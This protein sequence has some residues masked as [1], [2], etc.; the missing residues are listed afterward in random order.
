MA[1]KSTGEKSKKG[2][3]RGRSTAF[4]VTVG[5]HVAV[6]LA[7]GVYT[8]MT[9][10]PRE[11]PKFES[12]PVVRPKMPPKKLQV[13]VKVKKIRQP[14][15]RK[16]T[17]TPPKNKKMDVKMPAMTGVRG[18]M[19]GLSG[20]GLGSLGF[21]LRMDAL[22][23]NFFGAKGG[24]KHIVFIVDYSNSMS[25]E[26]EIVMRRE[27]VRVLKELPRETNVGL[28]FFAGPAWPAKRGRLSGDMSNW[29]RR[30][31][32]GDAQTHRPK[33][34]EDLP[35]VEYDRATKGR[36][37]D[38]VDLVETTS[39][40]GGTVYD[41][42]IYM[43]L[44][45]DPIPDTIFFMTD[46]ACNKERSVDSLQKMLTQLKAGGKKIPVLHTVGLGIGSNNMLIQM[47]DMMGGKSNFLTAEE[48]VQKYG[49]AD[50]ASILSRVE[51]KTRYEGEKNVPDEKYPVHFD[52]TR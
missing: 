42:P 26:K 36:I 33:N 10:L 18:A 44:R 47:A 49:P 35:E 32:K 16:T 31:G 3:V 9:V 38:L 19:D 50:K 51:N 23:I 43:A 25:G 5:V 13:P 17:I 24:G 7:A 46:G 27:V 37:G 34:W 40:T 11:E 39:L 28:I 12:K 15:F 52:L 21:N 20:S 48:Y 6:F 29:V 2:V 41:C 8:V 22:N 45:M 4:V 30:S 1:K 14:K